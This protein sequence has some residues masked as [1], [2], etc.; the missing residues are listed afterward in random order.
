MKL[1]SVPRLDY[2]VF[3]RTGEK[4]QK[5]DQISKMGDLEL[6]ELK[7][8]EDIRHTLEIYSEVDEF[9]M[10]VKLMKGWPRLMTSLKLIVICIWN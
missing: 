6:T 1:R 3:D 5:V 8:R 2:L 4:L 10:R 9:E 7:T